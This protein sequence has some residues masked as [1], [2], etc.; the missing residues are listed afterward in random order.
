MALTTDF[1][2]SALPDGW[3]FEAPLGI[4]S[5]TVAESR[6][7]VSIPQGTAHDSISSTTSPDNTVGLVHSVAGG[8]LDIAW[9]VDT[10][11]SDQRGHSINLLVKGAGSDAARFAWYKNDSATEDAPRHYT[12]VRAGGTGGTF[13]NLKIS[14]YQTGIPAWL[15]LRYTAATGLW[16]SLDSSDG[17]TWVLRED[18]TRAL[19]PAQ[20]KLGVGN[21]PSRTAIKIRINR[22][23]DLLAAGTTD[24]R[25]PAPDVTRTPVSTI[26]GTDAALP[27]GWVNDSIG[28]STVTFTGAVMRLDHDATQSNALPSPPTAS[29]R[30][31]W[32]GAAVQDWGLLLKLAAPIGN[33]ACFLTPTVGVYNGT[34]WIDQYSPGAGYG[35]EIQLGGIR[36]PIRVDDPTGTDVDGSGSTTGLNEVP[37]CWLKDF[38]GQYDMGL[39]GVRWFRMERVGRRVRVREWADG[40][41][42]P[43][44]WAL[45][46]GQDQVEDRAGAPALS[47]SHNDVRT[48]TARVDVARIEFYEVTTASTGVSG[49]GAAIAVPSV[50]AGA[51]TV[52]VSGS[53]QNAAPAARAA[54]SG[55]VLVSGGGAL[56]VA[57]AVL[58]GA[59]DAPILAAGSVLA[60]VAAADGGVTVAVT[61]TGAA[62][63]PAGTSSGTGTVT[64]TGT[65][66]TTGPGAAVTGTGSIGEPSILGEG[67]LRA[68]PAASGG[69]AAVT[70]GGTGGPVAPAASATG[71]AAVTVDGSG[72]LVAPGAIITGAGA[73]VAPGAGPPSTPSGRTLVVPMDPRVLVVPMDPRV[74]A[75][76]P[77]NRTVAIQAPR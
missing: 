3:T 4:G 19:T 32:T 16:E 57:P 53:G 27:T 51:G 69:T 62:T 28:T 1:D 68:Q 22:C 13:G 38:S 71:A 46:D 55:A 48:G 36:R 42:E 77:E 47:L 11:V 54:G 7:T 74:L 60:A 15:R 66:T 40:D 9:Q 17:L 73:L 49:S 50:A 18:G 24:L 39:G 70:V 12:Y 75:V 20:I 76:A 33:S 14:T 45:F 63:A 2:G 26:L 56:T 58:S 34:A 72:A 35:L 29:A 31:R 44:T 61:G 64:V 30:I 52:E 23:V 41:V 37:Y 25:A 10:D 59:G 8:D 43:S 6:A 21:N 65:G 67:D 5:L